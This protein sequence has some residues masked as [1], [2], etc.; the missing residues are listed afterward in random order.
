MN[1]R[2]GHDPRYGPKRSQT[3]ALASTRFSH[4]SYLTMTYDVLGRG[5]TKER[6]RKPSDYCR[7]G[8]FRRGSLLQ[9][10]SSLGCTATEATTTGDT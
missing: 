2:P 5:A 8:H 3:A 9:S 6:D 7:D 10:D 1:C 4:T